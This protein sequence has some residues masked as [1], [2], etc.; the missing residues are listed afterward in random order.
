MARIRTIKPEFFTSDDTCALSPYARLLYIGLWCEAD[1]EGRFKW[2]P[3]SFKRRYLP[4]DQLDVDALCGEIVA[5]GLVVLYGE[6]LAHIPTF[7]KHQQV[8]PREA[9]SSLPEPPNPKRPF[10]ASR[11][12]DASLRVDDAQTGREGKEG[13]GREGTLTTSEEVVGQPPPDLLK[14]EDPKAV[15][16]PVQA[17]VTLYHEILP[18]LRRCEKITD[19]RRKQIQQRWK[20]DLPDLDDWRNYFAF[21]RDSPWL[22]GKKPGTNGRPPFVAD[23]EWITTAGNFARI[24]EGKYHSG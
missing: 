12:T 2:S 10:A 16:C 9:Q 13:E 21:V 24:A 15:P 3:G 23:L 22:M 18:E 19:T 17:I 6:G 20:D 1:R 11:V 8:N 5:Q 4:D 7:S 14:D